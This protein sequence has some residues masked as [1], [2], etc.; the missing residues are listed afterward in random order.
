MANPGPNQLAIPTRREHPCPFLPCRGR[1]NDRL[2]RCPRERPRQQPYR[3][4][5]RETVLVPQYLLSCSTHAPKL[6]PCNLKLKALG[7]GRIGRLTVN[8]GTD[9]ERT[10]PSRYSDL[11]LQPG[12]TFRLETPGGGGY[13]N[14][15]D[16]DP[17]FVVSDVAESY[18]SAAAA[19]E[20]YGTVVRQEGGTYALDRAATETARRER[21]AL[22]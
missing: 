11:P 10:L 12:D 17:E 19:E 1:L 16:R 5:V 7:P 15:L 14:P 2:D 13:G 20:R 4:P 22:A 3:D 9:R 21:R 18:V 6:H 8:P